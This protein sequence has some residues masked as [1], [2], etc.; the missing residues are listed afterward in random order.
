V[1]PRVSELFAEFGYER[2]VRTNDLRM[3]IFSGAFGVRF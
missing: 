2:Y 1:L 3:N